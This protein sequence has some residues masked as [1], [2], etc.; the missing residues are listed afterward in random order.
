ML[1]KTL[2]AVAVALIASGLG[3]CKS[4][5]PSPSSENRG[6]DAPPTSGV[7]PPGNP[8]SGGTGTNGTNTG[9]G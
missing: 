5:D 9:G 1:R 8:P 7:V 4:A 2:A 3:A 6:D